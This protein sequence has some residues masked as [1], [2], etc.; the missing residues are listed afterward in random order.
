M[1]LYSLIVILSFPLL[2]F[3]QS[4]PAANILSYSDAFLALQMSAS[5]IGFGDFYPISQS[6]QTDSRSNIL[7]QC[8]HIA[9]FIGAQIASKTVGFA[10]TNVRNRELPDKMKRFCSITKS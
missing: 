1:L 9:G 3:E 6:W 10:D 2:W 8:L 5:T 7:S 4:H